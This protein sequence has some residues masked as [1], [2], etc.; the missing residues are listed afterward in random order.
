MGAAKTR[1]QIRATLVPG[2]GIG[3]EISKA[4][5]SI[6]DAAGAPFAWDLQQGGMAA[7]RK[8]GDPLPQALLERADAAVSPSTPASS[9]FQKKAENTI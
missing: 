3:P 5:V 9:L 2:D 7:I 4:V 6:L 8:G 1:K